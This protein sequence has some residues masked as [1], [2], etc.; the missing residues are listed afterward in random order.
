MSKLL[1]NLSYLPLKSLLFFF[2]IILFISINYYKKQI[3]LK[4]LS[5][6]ANLRNTQKL[7][8]NSIIS[9]WNNDN[10]LDSKYI[11]ICLSERFGQIK[12]P[13]NE[14]Y[15]VLKCNMNLFDCYLEKNIKNYKIIN[16]DVGTYLDYSNNNNFHFIN[17]EINKNKTRYW[18]SIKSNFDDKKEFLLN[19]NIFKNCKKIK[20]KKG[21]YFSGISNK[22]LRPNNKY[23]IY[24]INKPQL[25]KIKNNILIDKYLA[26]YNDLIVWSDLYSIKFKKNKIIFPKNKNLLL[27]ATGLSYKMMDS[28]C[29][30]RGMEVLDHRVFDR[31]SYLYD[32]EIKENYLEKMKLLSPY[33]WTRKRKNS[34]VYK[35][36]TNDEGLVDCTKI[37]TNECLNNEWLDNFSSYNLTLNGINHSLGFVM[38]AFKRLENKKIPIKLSSFHFN[39][40]SFVHQIGIKGL[41]NGEGM[42]YD[43]IDYL[44]WIEKNEFKRLS[45]N[46][47]NKTYNSFFN[48]NQKD[49]YIGFR[50][51]E[52]VYPK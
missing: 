14:Y 18:V 7:V 37:V 6:L 47:I 29:K 8:V 43:D 42:L 35:N 16:G 50:C 32:D 22:V 41:W 26:T 28:Y 31:L 38:E 10:Y 25:N 17:Y 12:V 24:K 1:K 49:L 11:K 45:E 46:F 44:D 36:L 39:S 52:T 19:E 23:S 21:L 4:E 33:P 15:R 5:N 51:M 27:P 20:I 30:S 13:K 40:N 9:K 2:P 48:K 34:F 3:K